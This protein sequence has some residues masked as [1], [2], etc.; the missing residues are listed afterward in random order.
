MS[1]TWEFQL[2][3]R[4]HFGPGGLRNLG[5]LAAPL[6]TTALLVGYR[7][8]DGMERHYDRAVRALTMA[9]VHV[10]PFF[11]VLPE[12]DA[13][14]P[15]EGGHAARHAGAEVIVGLGGGSAL[16]VA[17]AI[18]VTAKMEHGLTEYLVG[19]KQLSPTCPA[20]PSIA[21]PT[22]AGTGAEVSEVAVFV[23]PGVG[24][25][26]G[27]PLKCSLF[28]PAISP[29]IALIDPELTVGSPADLTAACGADALGH[30][31]EACLSRRANPVS[32]MYAHRA[33]ALIVD[34][35][36][37]AVEHPDDPGPREPLSLAA[38]LAGAAFSAAGVVAT[39]AMAQALGSLLHVPHGL[40][41]AIATPL[42]LRHN[43][44]SCVEQCAGLADACGITGGSARQRAERFVQRIVDLLHAVGLPDHVD[45][46]P[47]A[48][49]DLLDQL[50]QNA[51]AST[52]VSL[53]LNPCQVNQQRL[54]AMFE[55]VLRRP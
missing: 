51:F 26:A 36:L 48:P 9:G 22:T 21:V 28:G 37:V 55:D 54:R 41:V 38:M 4:V 24:T 47:N 34:N 33:I 16:D 35:L 3:T 2:T 52:R 42:V 11:Q 15:V 25:V 12:P 1:P 39:H 40:A 49:P 46:P 29:R 10:A 7:D 18:A 23:H 13:R 30:A 19:G 17:K 20:L 32:T 43:A 44:E 14:M 45:I 53:T 6:G 27:M 8:Q 50:V 5:E 31:I